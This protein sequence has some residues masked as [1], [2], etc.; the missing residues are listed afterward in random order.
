MSKHD[1]QLQF[2]R[3]TIKSHIYRQHCTYTIEQ[4]YNSRTRAVNKNMI[5]YVDATYLKY[6][7]TTTDWSYLETEINRFS[8]DPFIWA[9]IY[10]AREP[11]HNSTKLSK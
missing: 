10:L 7:I 9:N 4:K 11:K 8:P 2:V 5:D 1:K 3:I 6:D